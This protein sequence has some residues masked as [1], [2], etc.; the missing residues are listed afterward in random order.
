MN[1]QEPSGDASNEDAVPAKDEEVPAEEAVEEPVATPEDELSTEEQYEELIEP[2]KPRKIR[3]PR[4]RPK[5]LGA[6]ITVVVILII[7]IVW[8]LVSPKILPS[9]GVT[10][11]ESPVYAN[12][13]NFS[14]EHQSW[15]ALTEWGISVSGPDN[16]SANETF[17]LQVL[18]TK[19]S[20]EP[21]NFWFRGTAITLT[22]MTVIDENGTVLSSMSNKSDHQYGK[23][24][25]ISLS[26]KDPGSYVLK[27][28]GQ[29]LVYVDM[30]IGFL[31]V[32]KINLAPLELNPIVV[33]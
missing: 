8:T 28:T 14:A 20:E 33:G 4:G 27:V 32:E 24:A 11:V 6:I 10:Y 9:V 19:I 21:R 17:T 23:L 1:S 22:S 13:A 15:A 5:H 16:V 25:T 31:P 12:L 29:F 30:R 26:I 7:L 3:K 2:E 18:V